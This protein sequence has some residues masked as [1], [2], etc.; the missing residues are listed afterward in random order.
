MDRRRFL[1]LAGRAI[2]GIVGVALGVPALGFLAAPLRRRRDRSE[3]I[4]LTALDAVPRDRPVSVS[5]TADARDAFTHYPPG[6]IGT[7]WLVGSER[8]DEAVRCF[9]AVCPHLGCLIDYSASDGAFQCPCHA[10]G[11][12]LH[13]RRQFGPSPR[14]MDDLPVRVSEPDDRGRRWV[15]VA[16]REFQTGVADKRPIA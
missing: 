13:G 14:D 1:T 11:F 9:Q 4:R 3:Y 16:Y 5:V 15:E 2:R 8:D 6:P 12:D 7:V 10:S